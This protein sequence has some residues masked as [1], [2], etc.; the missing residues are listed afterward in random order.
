MVGIQ[1]RRGFNLGEGY[2]DIGNNTSKAWGAL[3]P[4]PSARWSSLTEWLGQGKH[5][6]NSRTRWLLRGSA[7]SGIEH[8]CSFV[9]GAQGTRPNPCPE[10]LFSLDTPFQQLFKLNQMFT[11]PYKAFS[12]R[13]LER[14]YNQWTCAIGK[15]VSWIISPQRE[16]AELMRNFVAKILLVIPM[17]PPL[18]SSPQYLGSTFMQPLPCANTILN[19]ILA[20]SPLILPTTR[21][22][23]WCN[24]FHFEIKKEAQL[25][26]CQYRF[27]S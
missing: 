26:K 19:T 9:H 22:G 21:W 2:T 5:S 24:Y 13:Q 20:S 4:L 27:S 14:I 23:R 6:I 3:G 7:S 16:K 11:L 17:E 10:L 8:Y 1:W 18:P 25:V 15:P 12:G